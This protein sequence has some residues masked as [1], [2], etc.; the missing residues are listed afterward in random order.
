[1]TPA[2]IATSPFVGN[3]DQQLGA[4][5]FASWYW[6]KVGGTSIAITFTIED[7]NRT[8]NNIGTITYYAGTNQ[9]YGAQAIQ[10]STE[11]PAAYT[12]VTRNLR[13]DARQVLGFYND[14][15]GT[16][17][18]GA[19]PSTG[20]SP[21]E[22]RYIAYK[23]IAF[24]GE[25]G[26]FDQLAITSLSGVDPIVS[27]GTE[28]FVATNADGSQHHFNRDG[29]LERITDRNG[30]A[31]NLDYT[32]TAPPTTQAAYTLAAIRAPGD[33]LPL[34][35]GTAQREIAVTRPEFE[36]DPIHRAAWLH[37]QLHRAVHRVQADRHGPDSGHPS[38]PECGMRHVRSHGLPHLR[39]LLAPAHDHP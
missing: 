8:T 28:D 7:L 6:R 30:N 26:L 3:L 34:S 1:M 33:G 9:G 29:M 14:N 17:S 31:I 19:A 32:F 16:S 15:D 11:L 35:S 13:D 36:H 25:F 2:A 38:P 4:Y 37:D 10:I 27:P 39:V 20:P 5:P 24:D 23:L 12:K 18:P 22:V 21:D